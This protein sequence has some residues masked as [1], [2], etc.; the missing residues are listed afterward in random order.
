MPRTCKTPPVSGGAS[1]DCFGGRSHCLSNPSDTWAQMLAER[2][3]LSPWMAHDLA[4][5]CFGSGRP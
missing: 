1:R 4:E 5:H 3:R 2:F